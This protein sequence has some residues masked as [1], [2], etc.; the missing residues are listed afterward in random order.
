MSFAAA[1]STDAA[2]QNKIL[3]YGMTALIISNKEMDDIKKKVMSLDD[4][5]LS[6]KGCQ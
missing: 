6:I 4:A 1:S 2:I 3:G 5:G